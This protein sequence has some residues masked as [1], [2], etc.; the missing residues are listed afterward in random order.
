M[1][2]PYLDEN[3]GI[4]KNTF[5]IGNQ[6]ELDQVEANIVA[7]K[8]LTVDKLLAE[9]EIKDFQYLKKIHK[10]LFQDLYP[11]AGEIR[12]I[13]IWKGEAVLGGDS[14]RYSTPR[15]I[16]KNG[17]DIIKKMEA[18][19]WN[20][21][22][23]EEQTEKY[24]KMITELWKNHVFREGNT[25][26]T[27]IFASHY[28][29]Q[30]GFSLNRELFHENA[31]FT[32]DALVIASDGM[33]ADYSHFKKIMRD[34]ILQGDQLYFKTKIAEAGFKP[35]E[36]LVKGLQKINQFYGR[37]LAIKEVSSL[38]KEKA[39]LTGEEK[40]IITEVGEDFRDQELYVKKVNIPER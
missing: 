14:V 34:A 3:T 18:V 31:K 28:A 25:R 19:L 12:S 36:R 8:L 10:H 26:T 21:L 16:E 35:E 38:Y 33:Y 24:T 2:D 30:R 7:G 32:R 15:E 29:I 27:M 9:F 5:Y 39:K 13:P 22:N 6:K 20:K 37:D 4:L 1:K 17:K 40:K 11:F 23:I